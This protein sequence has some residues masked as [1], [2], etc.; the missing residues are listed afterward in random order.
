MGVLSLGLRTQWSGRASARSFLLSLFVLSIIPRVGVAQIEQVIR[1]EPM[2][3]ERVRSPIKSVA[4]SLHF[5]IPELG[6]TYERCLDHALSLGATHVALVTQ[7]RMVDVY[8]SE[9]IMTGGEATPQETLIRVM[10][11]AKSRGLKV[12]L[13]PILWIEKRADGEWR[14]TLKPPHEDRWGSSYESWITSLATIG[15]LHKAEM[16]S[17]GSELSSSRRR[18]VDGDL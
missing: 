11:L 7:A 10:K 5:E 1:K 17:I 13:F 15:E 3:G 16:L 4:L 6:L 14:G 18:V 12:I 2:R 9:V 8:A